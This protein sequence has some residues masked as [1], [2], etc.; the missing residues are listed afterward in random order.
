[1]KARMKGRFRS[2]CPVFGKK[3]AYERCV[4][5]IKKTI[6]PARPKSTS[7]NRLHGFW[8]FGA[9]FH[10]E[11]AIRADA[12]DFFIFTLIGLLCAWPIVGVALTI[13][14]VFFG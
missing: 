7:D 10:G 5:S 2:K 3:L 8:K 11:E 13:V 12:T 1:M 9:E 4:N 14:R 6:N